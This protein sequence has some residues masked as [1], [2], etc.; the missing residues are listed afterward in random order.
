[1][2]ALQV[3]ERLGEVIAGVVLCCGMHLPVVGLS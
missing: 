2:R 3:A 1:M